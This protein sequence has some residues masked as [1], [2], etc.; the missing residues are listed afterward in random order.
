MDKQ[1]KMRLGWV[2]LYLETG[3]AGLTCRRCGISRPTLRLWVRRYEKEGIDGLQSRSRRPKHSPK[4]KRSPALEKRILT[5][6]RQRN[7]GARRIQSE[8]LWEDNARLSLATIH[9]VLVNAKVGPLKRPPRRK[10]CKRYE[11]PIPGDRVQMDTCKISTGIY[12]YTAVDDCTRCRVLRVYPRRTAKNTL[13]F[14]D[15]VIEEMGFPIQRVQTDR[16]SE[17][18][19]YKV[20]ERLM[21][22]GIKFRPIRPASP[23]LNGKVERSQRTDKL[24]FYATCDL[25]DP[26]LADR[27]SEWQHYYNWR[28][29]HGA[30]K[31]KTPMQRLCELSKDTP[32]WEDVSAL[33]DPTKE[34]IQERNYQVDLRLRKLKECL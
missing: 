20:Q 4:R 14:V 26:D 34:R 33:Y 7:L 16:G 6:R 10:S 9:K 1:I 3:D 21:D 32:F 22:Y 23:H 31:G 24:E 12:Q 11:R 8:L 28:R 27:L 25:D 18:F 13:D 19:A 17:F 29:P 2:Q 30:F 5:L 15:A